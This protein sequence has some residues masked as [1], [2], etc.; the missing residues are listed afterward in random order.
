LDRSSPP[1]LASTSYDRYHSPASPLASHLLGDGIDELR[2]LPL[3]HSFHLSSSLPAFVGVTASQF[4]EALQSQTS[5][6]PVTQLFSSLRGA[7]SRTDEVIRRGHG[8]PREVPHRWR[9]CRL[10]LG[11]VGR[12]LYLEGHEYLMFVTTPP[13]PPPHPTRGTTLTMSTSTLG[14]RS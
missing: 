2:S 13:P 1:A 12:F 10:S 7:C 9:S 6:S 3:A 14:S 4:H 8:D 5:D 11:Q